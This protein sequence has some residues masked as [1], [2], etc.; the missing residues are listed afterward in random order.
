ML[1]RSIA[2]AETS[3]LTVIESH[4]LDPAIARLTLKLILDQGDGRLG[5]HRR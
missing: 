3:D 5:L 2:A 4:T 1:N